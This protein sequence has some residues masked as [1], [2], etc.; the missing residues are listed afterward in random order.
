LLV[1]ENVDAAEK[2]R[3]LQPIWEGPVCFSRLD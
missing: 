1:H 2:P 3:L